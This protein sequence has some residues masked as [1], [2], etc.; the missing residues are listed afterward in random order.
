MKNKV[1]T[2]NYDSDDHW[3]RVL[4]CNQIAHCYYVLS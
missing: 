3:H 2:Q 4:L 1:T